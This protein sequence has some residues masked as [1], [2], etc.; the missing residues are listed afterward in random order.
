M[1]YWILFTNFQHKNWCSFQHLSLEFILKIFLKFCKFQHQYSYKMYCNIKECIT[2]NALFSLHHNLPIRMVFRFF[3]SQSGHAI[4]NI[5]SNKAKIRPYI[6]HLF[7]TH[8]FT[9]PNTFHFYF[10]VCSSQ[11]PLHCGQQTQ[12]ELFRE[13]DKT[14]YCVWVKVHYFAK[15]PTYL[16]CK[17]F[18]RLANFWKVILPESSQTTVHSFLFSQLFKL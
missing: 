11:T 18:I 9:R 4:F 15:V 10:V 12:D 13:L 3:P 5:G 8:G 6:H 1:Y 17:I 7:E 14:L 16:F 2:I